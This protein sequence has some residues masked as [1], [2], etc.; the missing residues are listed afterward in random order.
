MLM[1]GGGRTVLYGRNFSSKKWPS[2]HLPILRVSLVRQ[3]INVSPTVGEVVHLHSFRVIQQNYLALIQG[4]QV[5][6]LTI[7]FPAELLQSLTISGA[8]KRNTHNRNSNSNSSFLYFCVWWTNEALRTGQMVVRWGSCRTN[9]PPTKL[10]DCGGSRCCQP[11]A[12]E[13]TLYF[14]CVR[15]HLS[16]QKNSRK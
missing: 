5:K 16:P 13:R 7:D 3:Q 15:A 1:G 11:H 8:E 6:R 12:R 14:T 2:H 9:C 10:T 4:R